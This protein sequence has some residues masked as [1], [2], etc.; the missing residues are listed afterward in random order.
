MQ[1][2]KNIRLLISLVIL[3]AASLVILLGN[4]G[5]K[6]APVNKDLFLIENLERIDQV[7]LES[8]ASKT[9]LRFDGVKWRI[10]GRYEAD[11]QMIKVLFAT[12][13]QTT[14]KRLVAAHLQDSLRKEIESNGVKIS[15]Y[16]AGALSKE[17]RSLGNG[18][19]T[20]TYFSGEDKKVYVVNIPGYRVFIAA[21]FALP[22]NEWRNKQVFNFNWQNIKSLE[23]DLGDSRQSFKGSFNRKMFSIEGI[24]TDTT[25]LDQFMDALLQLRAETILDSI[26][27]KKYD[28]LTKQ[29]PLMSIVLQDI[30]NRSY[31]LQV[32]PMIKGSDFVIGKV[33]DETILVNPFALQK[34]YRKRDYFIAR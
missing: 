11:N 16:E 3:I 12:L 25:K 18:A 22:P 34:I 13:K 20:E 26:Q 7:V 27:S 29:K 2:K 1:R 17:F 15:C 6:D 14:P 24:A 30:A 10:N 31:P 28:S 19:K 4:S 5:K 21:I 23:V 9:E 32:F 33:N 8:P